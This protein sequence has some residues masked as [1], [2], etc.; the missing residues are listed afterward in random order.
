MNAEAPLP[1]RRLLPALALLLLATPTHAIR[2]S[3][4]Q[5]GTWREAD[6]PHVVIAD[7]VVPL[8]ETLE[9][10]PGCIVLF[11][12]GTALDVAGTLR[13]RALPSAPVVMRSGDHFPRSGDWSG[14]TVGPAGTLD[15]ES[16]GIRDAVVGIRLTPGAQLAARAPRAWRSVS[17]RSEN[18][19]RISRPSRRLASAGYR[20]SKR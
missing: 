1:Y 2:V 12:P 18:S 13:A 3:G 4:D 6:T 7:V 14:L 15:L 17:T 16:V 10:E 11:A 19:R 9:I 8:G 5:S 20:N